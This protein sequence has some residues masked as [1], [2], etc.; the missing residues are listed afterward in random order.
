[1]IVLKLPATP[2]N[3]LTCSHHGEPVTDGSGATVG[4][5]IDEFVYVLDLESGNLE[6]TASVMPMPM[7]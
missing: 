1:M 7:Q 3:C 4:F 5:R 2:E 6:E